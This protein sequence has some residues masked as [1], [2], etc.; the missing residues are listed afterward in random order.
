MMFGRVD[1][2]TFRLLL[3]I[4]QLHSSTTTSA[5]IANTTTIHVVQLPTTTILTACLKVVTAVHFSTVRRRHRWILL[6]LLISAVTSIT[7]IIKVTH[8]KVTT[9]TVVRV[10][11]RTANVHILLDVKVLEVIAKV[12]LE[13]TNSIVQLAI[14]VVVVSIKTATTATHVLFK[15][16]C[17]RAHARVTHITT[18]HDVVGVV[19]AG[20]FFG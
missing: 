10:T 13:I 11:T 1:W 7:H 14:L 16:I 2:N 8:E 6:L 17:A 18:L 15:S 12:A 3:L 20:Y 4:H 19:L 5:I 9:G